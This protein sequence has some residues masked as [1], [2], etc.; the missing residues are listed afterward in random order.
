MSS[1]YLASASPRRRELL[2]QIGVPFSL[3]AVSVDETPLPD[4]AAEDYVRRVALDKARA[5][6]AV[7]PD[8]NA[9][10]LAADTSVVLDQRI[11]GKPADR[12]DG[13]AMLAALS[14]R[15][16]RVLTAI[17]LANRC[18]CEVRLVDS[19]VEFRSIDASE[20][21]AYW[22]SGEPRDKAGGYAIQGWGAVFVSQLHGSYSAV[23]GLPLCETAQLLDRFGLPRWSKSAG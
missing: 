14:G 8:A 1:L 4:E 21:Q 18:A 5:G 20:A 17:V 16:H 3:L 10:V 19:E 6:L 22:D 23:V 13:L 15:S 12:A 2:Q 7:L 9:C 11:L